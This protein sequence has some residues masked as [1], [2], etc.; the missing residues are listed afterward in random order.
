MKLE[1]LRHKSGRLK[2]RIKRIRIWRIDDIVDVFKD[3]IGA[4]DMRISNNKSML[5]HQEFFKSTEGRDVK[6]SK[7]G[8]D[9]IDIMEFDKLPVY[10]EGKVMMIVYKSDDPNFEFIDLYTIV[11]NDDIFRDD[12]FI[13]RDKYGKDNRKETLKHADEELKKYRKFI[14]KRKLKKS[15]TTKHNILKYMKW[16]MLNKY[17]NSIPEK[18]NDKK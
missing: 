13:L 10:K 9:K 14:R 11:K 16:E 15:I 4:D 2:G 8:I 7:L 3:K 18:E 12:Q 6:L 5:E 17:L 1:V